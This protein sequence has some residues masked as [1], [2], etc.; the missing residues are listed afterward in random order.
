MKAETIT[1]Y[2]DGGSRGNP[3]PAATGVVI[4]RGE[5]VVW[6]H[7]SVIG[8]TTNN[9]AE[10]S[11]VNEGLEWLLDDASRLEGIGQINF[12]MDSELVARQLGG[13]YKVKNPGLKDIYFSIQDK[14]A[15]IGLPVSFTHIPRAQNSHADSMVNK[16]LDNKI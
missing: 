5:E 9:V 16:A 15:R 4:K 6:E 10:Y 14:I 13:L 8:I 11:A 12:F 7:G 2:T 3:G 1:I